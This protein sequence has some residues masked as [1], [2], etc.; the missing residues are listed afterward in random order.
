MSICERFDVAVDGSDGSNRPCV[1]CFRDSA[2]CS[3]EGEPW[4]TT[5]GDPGFGREKEKLCRL[6]L[7]LLAWEVN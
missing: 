3:V 1:A 2:L 7:L 5:R 4:V 6:E